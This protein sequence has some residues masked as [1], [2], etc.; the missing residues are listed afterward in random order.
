VHISQLPHQ[1]THFTQE[2]M[3]GMKNEKKS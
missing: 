1:L 3:T 2:I